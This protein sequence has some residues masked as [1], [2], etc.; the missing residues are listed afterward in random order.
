MVIYPQDAQYAGH[1]LKGTKKNRIFII[2]LNV[3][4]GTIKMN[5]FFNL[6]IIW[7]TDIFK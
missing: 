2:V 1:I 4:I 6:S 3:I 5:E 7:L